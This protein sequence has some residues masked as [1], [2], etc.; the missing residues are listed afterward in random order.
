MLF[1]WVGLVICY[2]EPVW[3]EYMSLE[4]LIWKPELN[5]NSYSSVGP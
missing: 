5:V 2:L 1:Y 3:R 4:Y